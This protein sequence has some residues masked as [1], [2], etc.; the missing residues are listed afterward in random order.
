MML[1][2]GGKTLVEFYYEGGWGKGERKV[3]F[4]RRGKCL[5]VCVLCWG[6][7]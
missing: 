3:I 7:E 6:R 1:S 4:E 2:V 5:G